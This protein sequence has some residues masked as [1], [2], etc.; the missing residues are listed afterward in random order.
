MLPRRLKPFLFR[1][2]SA[3][4]LTLQ[5]CVGFSPVFDSLWPVLRSRGRKEF[6]GRACPTLRWVCPFHYPQDQLPPLLLA[7]QPRPSCRRPHVPLARKKIPP[8]LLS[9]LLL[10]PRH[11]AVAAVPSSSFSNLAP[12]VCRVHARR[13]IISCSLFGCHVGMRSCKA[14]KVHHLELTC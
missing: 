6:E 3:T 4:S 14:G 2:T 1:A 8:L 11:V 5:F 7:S 9:P 13:A 12:P 10:P